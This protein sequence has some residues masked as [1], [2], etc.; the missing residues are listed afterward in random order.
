[1]KR[2]K[3]FIDDAANCCC[4]VD[5]HES[6]R[7]CEFEEVAHLLADKGLLEEQL[8]ETQDQRSSL[9]AT[10]YDI[11]KERD[12]LTDELSEAREVLRVCRDNLD[13]GMET[14]FY[15]ALVARIDAFIKEKK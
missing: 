3:H 10:N 13:E 15:R 8:R 7:F 4:E 14:E 6:G 2:Y 9:L 5:E 11:R 1:M 12:R